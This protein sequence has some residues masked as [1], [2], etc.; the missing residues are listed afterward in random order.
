[1]EITAHDYILLITILV[2]NELKPF[3]SEIVLKLNGL[4]III[5]PNGPASNCYGDCRWRAL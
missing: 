3:F 1:M 5:T 2:T 4:I